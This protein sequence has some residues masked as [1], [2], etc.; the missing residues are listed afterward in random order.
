MINY[1]VFIFYDIWYSTCPCNITARIHKMTPASEKF[2]PSAATKL[3]IAKISAAGN[4][5]LNGQDS[6]WTVDGIPVRIPP[7]FFNKDEPQSSKTNLFTVHVYLEYSLHIILCTL[8]WLVTRVAVLLICFSKNTNSI[9]CISWDKVEGN[10]I[11]I[12][13]KTINLACTSE[14][15]VW[16][17]FLNAVNFKG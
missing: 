7:Y 12:W 5:L 14:V 3:L 10:T 4:F 6:Q 17:Q 15:F 1:T 11:E 16:Q 2:L 9:H 13:G 8:Q